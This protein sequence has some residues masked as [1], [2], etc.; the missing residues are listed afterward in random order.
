MRN[1][2]I[3]LFL[4]FALSNCTQAQVV[5]KADDP[6]IHYMG[7]V[8]KK[9]DAMILAWPGTSLNINFTG[10]SVKA[11]L[12]DEHAENSYNVIIDGKVIAKLL[13]DKD[14]KE[15][16][17]ADN[18][19]QGKHNLELFK[20]TEWTMGKTYVY[21]L[22]L[23]D[24]AKLL[25]AS[26]I[27]KHKIEFFGNSITCGYAVEDSSGKDR[28]TAPYENNYVS[29]AA[30][31]ARHFNAE[32]Y[33]TAR[34]GIGVTISWFPQIMSEMY[35]LVD[36]GDKS[37]K[38]DFSKYQPDLV[39]VNL[40]QND[41]WLVKQPNH[42]EFKAR[43]GTIAPTEAQLIKAYSDLIKSIRSNYPK[44]QIICA[45]GNM[46]ATQAGSAWPGYIQKA[47]A[48]LAD[49]KI[50]TCFFPYKGTGGHPNGKEQQAMA[51]QLI[52]FID[53]HIKW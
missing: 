33:C 17:L 34:S 41:S 49:K 16:T 18:L 47:V 28:G 29:Y 8:D 1:S 44:A 38:W 13:L 51:D 5:V 42:P 53:Q 39:V 43:F 23:D 12:S 4:L 24:K 15:Y 52:G 7:R 50:Y 35:D 25:P 14:K 3:G 20:R 26:P 45:L 27:K 46:D 40:F 9:D 22:L 21:Q 32:Y 36:G 31:T 6:H 2:F 11:V 37:R 19:P 48:G 30:I 10:T